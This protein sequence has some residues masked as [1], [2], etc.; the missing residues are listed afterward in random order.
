MQSKLEY[1]FKPK[2]L[3]C[4]ETLAGVGDMRQGT[5]L[6]LFNAI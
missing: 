5:R 1:D 4:N 3:R 2:V 6:L